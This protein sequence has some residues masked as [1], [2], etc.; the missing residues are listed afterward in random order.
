MEGRGHSGGRGADGG[1]GRAVMQRGREMYG[2]GVELAGDGEGGGCDSFVFR[3]LRL[4]HERDRGG[5][6]APRALARAFEVARG[7][8]ASTRDALGLGR[9]FVHA[10]WLLA[11]QA[12]EVCDARAARQPLAP[13]VVHTRLLGMGRATF[14]LQQTMHLEEEEEVEEAEEEED[15]RHREG[16]EL[17]GGRTR[18]GRGQRRRLGPRIA[19]VTG[20][21]ICTRVVEEDE[22]GEGGGGAGEGGGGGG[23]GWRRVR[24]AAGLPDWFRDMHRGVGRGRPDAGRVRRVQECESAVLHTHPVVCRASDTDTNGHVNHASFLEYFLDALAGMGPGG[25]PPLLA[26]AGVSPAAPEA[27]RSVTLEY[28]REAFAGDVLQVQVT[29][30]RQGVARMRLV[31]DGEGTEAASSPLCLCEVHVDIDANADVTV[32]SPS[33]P[34]P[35]SKL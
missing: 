17:G 30:P 26:L 35:A 25:V 7:E 16:G 34:S 9:L 22:T 23:G 2:S 4:S 10:P 20:T 11:S 19:Q 12:L 33:P 29:S 28:A 5:G 31:R 1:D 24:R 21:Y 15:G 27:V 14:E 32:A 3:G 8:A 13:V 6:V 18:G